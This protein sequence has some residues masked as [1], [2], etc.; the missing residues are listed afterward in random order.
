V[1][2]VL[3]IR[4]PHSAIK[5]GRKMNS[6]GRKERDAETEVKAH[7][8]PADVRAGDL[9]H[10][11]WENARPVRIKRY[12]SGE[13]APVGRQAEARLLWSDKALCVRFI[14]QQTEPMV[15]SPRPQ[16]KR[17]T[18]R[19]WEHD[20]CELFITPNTREPE[21]YFEF[22]AAPTGEWLDLKIHLKPD[23]RETDWEF[24]SGMTV[25][26]RTDGNVITIAMRVPWKAFGQRPQAG[27]RWRGNL[28]R[29]AGTGATRGYITW[30]P[31]YTEEPNFHVPTS[32]GWILW[33]R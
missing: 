17:K 14:Y 7:Y 2:A 6:A 31:T 10:S 11:A 19:L 29:C 25:A 13:V 30:Q 26:T 33:K 24:H 20:V 22:E 3:T 18:L 15:V 9:D 1:R 4:N 28:F 12:W 21:R 8:T 16:T 5:R 23:E 27:E 32:F